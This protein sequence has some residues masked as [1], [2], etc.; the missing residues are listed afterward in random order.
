MRHHSFSSVPISKP[1]SFLFATC[2]PQLCFGLASGKTRIYRCWIWRWRQPGIFSPFAKRLLDFWWSWIFWRNVRQDL[3][4]MSDCRR[5]SILLLGF[6]RI[7]SC[8][9]HC[10][11]RYCWFSFRSL[12][13]F[14][15]IAC[16]IISLFRILDRINKWRPISLVKVRVCL[17]WSYLLTYYLWP[18]KNSQWILSFFQPSNTYQQV[19]IVLGRLE[20]SCFPKILCK[21]SGNLSYILSYLH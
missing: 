19:N 10:R 4:I 2:Y 9:A 7:L 20:W 3:C 16:R 6:R 12:R 11:C 17:S 14:W 15:L 13:S 21:L 8:R 5:F 18:Y 1:C